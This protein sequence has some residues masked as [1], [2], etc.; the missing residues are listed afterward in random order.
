MVNTET[1]QRLELGFMVQVSEF[2]V[3]GVVSQGLG[4]RVSDFGLRVSDFGLRVS[5]FG[6]RVCGGES[7]VKGCRFMGHL[8]AVVGVVPRVIIHSLPNDK[9]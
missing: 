4:L 1:L 3:S 7:R 8:D 9:T 2:E 6:A 5:G